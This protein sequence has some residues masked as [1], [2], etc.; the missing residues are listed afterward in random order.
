M[1]KLDRKKGQAAIEQAPLAA[2]HLRGQA[3]MEYLMTYG[4]AL[5]VIVVVL[6]ALLF[7]NPFR[8]PEQ[9][10]FDTPSFVCG[11]PLLAANNANPAQSGIL[12]AKI[13]NGFSSGI[14]V[15][16]VYCTNSRE[17]PQAPDRRSAQSKFVPANNDCSLEA[18]KCTKANNA[19][20]S[21]GEDFSG[22]LYVYYSLLDDADNF[23]LRVSS[24]TISAKAQKTS[25]G[26]AT[27]TTNC[28]GSTPASPPA[29]PP[30]ESTDTNLTSSNA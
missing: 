22:K 1:K 4:W 21:E 23:P 19:P 5:L 9:C 25:A 17:A 13:T 28:A 8:A 10:T 11:K 27:I 16:G 30:T 6:A 20:I 7:I 12:Y 2:R 26:T 3:A 18:I 24:A 29:N 15:Y 14:N